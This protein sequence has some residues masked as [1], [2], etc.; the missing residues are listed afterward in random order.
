MIKWLVMLVLTGVTHIN[1]DQ[2]FRLNLRAPGDYA[3]YLYVLTDILRITIQDLYV[4]RIR[5]DQ[6]NF[7]IIL[8]FLRTIYR[9]PEFDFTNRTVFKYFFLKQLDDMHRLIVELLIQVFAILTNIF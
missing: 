6:I 1:V 5:V 2:Y 9:R 3:T 8:K 7:K 4:F